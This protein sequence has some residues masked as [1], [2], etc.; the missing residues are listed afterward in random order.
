[1]CDNVTTHSHPFFCLVAIMH[2]FF[3]SESARMSPMTLFFQSQPAPTQCVLSPAQLWAPLG[4]FVMCHGWTPALK[5]CNQSQSRILAKLHMKAGTF[6]GSPS[7]K[8]YDKLQSNTKKAQ[9]NKNNR[10]LCAAGVNTH[11]EKVCQS[12]S[13]RG[14]FRSISG[15]SIVRLQQQMNFTSCEKFLFYFFYLFLHYEAWTK[16]V[17][18][19]SVFLRAC[20]CWRMDLVISNQRWKPGRN[21]LVWISGN[22]WEESVS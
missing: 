20:Q 8:Y 3:F 22:K 21:I 1:M 9:L 2:C 4:L 15:P 6:E 19:K 17:C 14:L 7:A 10:C 16:V 5:H 18:G 13:P 11:L 12:S